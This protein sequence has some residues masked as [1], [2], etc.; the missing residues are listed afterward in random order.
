MRATSIKLATRNGRRA[1]RITATQVL[2]LAS[3]AWESGQ[4]EHMERAL[5][6]G[7]KK[8][9]MHPVLW[10]LWAES[11][12]LA[13]RWSAQ[14]W[15]AWNQCRWHQASATVRQ[16]YVE[17]R[18]KWPEWDGSEQDM[19]GVP[20]FLWKEGGDGDYVLYSRYAALLEDLGAEVVW[21]EREGLF[22]GWQAGK[23]SV[24]C[25]V[26]LQSLPGCFGTTPETIPPPLTPERLGWPAWRG[27]GERV[28]RVVCRWTGNPEQGH[29][30]FRS[31][32]RERPRWADEDMPGV[33]WVTL[34]N[35]GSWR[36]TL[37][38]LAQIDL[39]IT[40]DT[41]LFH[42][43]ATLG[44]PTWLL[45]SDCHYPVYGWQG[46]MLAHWYPRGNVRIF[47]QHANGEWE[48]TLADVRR[49]LEEQVA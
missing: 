40:V 29:D 47:T 24:A 33:E 44:V 10:T 11:E 4:R 6:W 38:A 25:F 28:K 3:N 1:R 13:G 32:Y 14:M 48:G 34:P 2:Q 20:I 23:L 31:I 36:P 30:A 22:P 46:E 7:L 42:V 8:W 16:D 15:R 18:R 17:L 19:A 35:V 12:L 9:P 26:P 41:A 21:H 27:S 39:V 49:A 45:L 37:E 5:E 43:A